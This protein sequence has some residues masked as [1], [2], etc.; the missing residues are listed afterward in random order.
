MLGIWRVV[1]PVDYNERHASHHE[2]NSSHKEDQSPNLL[3]GPERFLLD[4][5]EIKSGWKDEDQHGSRRSPYEPKD[6]FDGG[7]KDDQDVVE[8]NDYCGNQ[9]MLYPA[10]GSLGEQ[11]CDH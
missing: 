7:H 9:E 6:V 11:Q 5:L 4:K 2:D 10:E 1:N 8:R 3:G